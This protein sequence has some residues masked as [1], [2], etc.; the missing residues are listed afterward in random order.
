MQIITTKGTKIGE[1]KGKIIRTIS[2]KHD[3]PNL[4]MKRKIFK[5][6]SQVF[7]DLATQEDDLDQKYTKVKE[8]IKFLSSEDVV[9]CLI[10]L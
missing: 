3:Y 6:E 7:K 5:D 8:F 1:E 4:V 9:Y 10:N 2:P